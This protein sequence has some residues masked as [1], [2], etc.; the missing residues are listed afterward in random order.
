M[1]IKCKGV[2]TKNHKDGKKLDINWDKNFKPFELNFTG[3]YWTTVS[4]VKNEEH[5]KTI[6]EI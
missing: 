5:I 1:K 2:V 3:G 6:F 4:V